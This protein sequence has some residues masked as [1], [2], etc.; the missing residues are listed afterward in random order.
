FKEVTSLNSRTKTNAIHI[1]LNF[2]NEDKLN[3]PLLM[4][5]A[6]DYMQRISFGEQP[7]LVYRHYDA[8]HPHIHIATTNI[9]TNGKR[10]ETH[11]LGKTKSEKARR[12]IEKNHNLVVAEEQG[13]KEITLLKPL[14]KA[15]YGDTE[16]KAALSNIVGQVV[17][18]YKYTS[19]A[20]LN[21]ILKQYN[22]TAYRGEPGTRM[23]EGGG[24]VYSITDGVGNMR[25][26]PVK[27]SVLYGKPTLT[28]LQ[29][30]FERN[31]PA[32]KPHA[33]RLMQMIDIAL[34]TNN[35]L[36]KQAFSKA[37]RKKGIATTFHTNDQ[38]RTYGITFVDNVTRCAFKGSVLGKGY[39]TA[40]ILSRLDGADKKEAGDW[41][42]VDIKEQKTSQQQAPAKWAAPDL[43]G[44]H[45]LLEALTSGYAEDQV[46]YGFRRKKKGR[47]V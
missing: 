40:A 39:S 35:T 42:T 9:Q 4:K 28:N 38:G 41:G 23:Y 26:T 3:D 27:S 36:T 1:S 46:A 16:T 30:R 8:G 45:D 34:N 7:Y 14:D 19:L 17:K 13:K 18:G 29:K 47:Q 21:A 33:P 24:L 10:I 12:A 20:E 22:V 11:N 15:T 6:D 5:I 31:K 32:R 43:S 2:S 44:I 25:G 37:M